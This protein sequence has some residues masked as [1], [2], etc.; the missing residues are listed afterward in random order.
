M[1]SVLNEIPAKV[2]YVADVSGSCPLRDEF[3]DYAVRNDIP[4]KKH[5]KGYELL[6]PLIDVSVLYPEEEKEKAG[7]N[8]AS[9]VLRL[10]NKDVSAIFAGD[11]EKDNV[12]QNCDTDI[13]KVAHHGS[14]NGSTQEFLDNNTPE[15]AVISLG[16]NNVYNFPRQETIDKLSGFT[17]KI[18]RTDLNGTVRIFCKNRSYSVQTLR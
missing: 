6:F 7:T 13:L 5:S 16:E 15:I 2:V 12:L 3:M 17:V 1:I 8:E 14:K 4:V 18:Y 9:L 11:L 10:E